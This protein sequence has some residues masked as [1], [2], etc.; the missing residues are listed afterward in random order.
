MGRTLLVEKERNG[1][2]STMLQFLKSMR[3]CCLYMFLY[4]AR[5]HMRL[6]TTFEA[7]V[8]A[9]SSTALGAPYGQGAPVPT[10]LG[11]LRAQIPEMLAP[12]VCSVQV[13]AGL[14]ERHRRHPVP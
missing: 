2:N 3:F 1:L 8:V 10:L 11:L 13:G 6:L 12:S 9:L 5:S 4:A 14:F 7:V